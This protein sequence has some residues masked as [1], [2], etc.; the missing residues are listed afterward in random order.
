VRK[1]TAFRGRAN[2]T[3]LPYKNLGTISLEN[4]PGNIFKV[5][6]YKNRFPCKTTIHVYQALTPSKGRYTPFEIPV[7]IH[8]NPLKGILMNLVRESR[9]TAVAWDKVIK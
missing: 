1:A 3:A 5:P 2:K 9:M 4:V 8:Q 6:I 7:Q